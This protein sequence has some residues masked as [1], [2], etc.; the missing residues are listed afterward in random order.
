MII[1]SSHTH[2]SILL[3]VF[4]L[5]RGNRVCLSHRLQCQRQGYT[6]QPFIRWAVYVVLCSS[7]SMSSTLEYKQQNIYA[8]N[9]L[10]HIHLNSWMHYPHSHSH[11]T[12][13]TN[14]VGRTY[15]RS[16]HT[17]I[18]PIN[19]SCRKVCLVFFPRHERKTCLKFHQMIV[20]HLIWMTV[21]LLLLFCICYA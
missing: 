20:A 14:P 3:L 6:V 13:T 10:W 16:S 7:V 5:R 4:H 18:Y 12:T 11:S 1:N 8:W 2:T 17:Q 15:T 9:V 21:W 19:Y